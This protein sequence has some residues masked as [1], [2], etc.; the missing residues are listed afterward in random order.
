MDCDTAKDAIS[1]ELDHEDTGVDPAELHAHVAGCVGCG[2]FAQGVT[3]LHRATRLRAAEPVPDLVGAVLAQVATPRR[4]APDWIPYALMAVALT[5]LV[6]AVPALLFGD[7]LGASVHIARELGSWDVALGVG[8]LYA[9]WRPERAHG[10]LPFAA[11]LG[12]AMALTAGLDVASGR[13]ALLSE[14]HHLLELLGLGLLALLA[15]PEWGQLRPRP[16]APAA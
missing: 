15:R 8:L 2:R 11:A 16:A 1:A 14:A 12:G 13:E 10:L 3:A 7:S 6:L 9:A 4:R 5:Q